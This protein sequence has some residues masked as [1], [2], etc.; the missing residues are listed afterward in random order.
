MIRKKK[1]KGK[2]NSTKH[3]KDGI[4]FKSSLELKMYTLLKE[5][6]IKAVYEG[7]S[8]ILVDAFEYPSECFERTP[9]TDRELKDKGKYDKCHI[10]LISLDL[11]QK[12]LSLL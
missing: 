4:N 6:G 1:S 3:T 11:I 12:I 2:I 7:K 10:A 8:F 5:A 9:K